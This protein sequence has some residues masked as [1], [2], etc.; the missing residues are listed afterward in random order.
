M[1]EPLGAAA[2]PAEALPSVGVFGAGIALEKLKT[3]EAGNKFRWGHIPSSMNVR[4][5]ENVR[6]TRFAQEARA[7]SSV[8]SSFYDEPIRASLANPL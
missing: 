3:D 4:D 8:C 1:D 6:W 7:R 2:R 5:R